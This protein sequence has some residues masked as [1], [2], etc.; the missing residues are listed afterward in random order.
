MGAAASIGNEISK[1][2]DSISNAIDNTAKSIEKDPVGSIAIITTAIVA[3]AYLPEVIAA[4]DVAQ[5]VPLDKAAENY[6]KA[7]V[8]QQIAS[9]VS[10]NLSNTNVGGVTGPDNI[11]VGGGFNPATGAGSAATAAASAPLASKPVATAAGNTTSAIIKGQD[12]LTAITTGGIQAGVSSITDS[13]PFYS[14]LSPAQQAAVK[15]V[16][17]T[18]LRGGDPS[19]ALVNSAINAG[20]AEARAQYNAP[21]PPANIAMQENI[22]TPTPVA[23]NTNAPLG[24]M[25]SI[26]SIAPAV[27]SAPAPMSTTAEAPLSATTPSLADAQ[28]AAKDIMSSYTNAQAP[29]TADT[30]TQ[31]ASS[32]G[33]LPATAGGLAQQEIE[34]IMGGDT[35][36]I[37]TGAY[38][39]LTAQ[40]NAYI[41]QGGDPS[42]LAGF[43][44]F[45]ATQSQDV[46]TGTTDGILPS[47][48]GNTGASA[49]TAPDA[50]LIA[51]LSQQN[52]APVTPV[53]PEPAA[54]VEP[55]PV[56][57]VVAEQ[58]SVVEQ[59]PASPLATVPEAPVVAEP[60]APLSTV[61]APVAET[62]VLEPK[63]SEPSP[64]ST[65]TT[66]SGNLINETGQITNVARNPETNELYT[67]LATSDSGDKYVPVLS[68]QGQA[69][70][71]APTA[72][73]S[74][75][76]VSN[77]IADTSNAVTP[78]L[79]SIENPVTEAPT[80]TTEAPVTTVDTSAP[81]TDMG[82]VNVTGTRLP[83]GGATSAD[84]PAVTSAAAKTPLDQ[85]L[86]SSPQ[87]LNA[88]TVA[89]MKRRE[90]QKLRQLFDSLT[91]ELSAILAER[92]I[93][94]EQEASVQE[95][96]PT[97]TYTPK[98]MSTGGAMT[99]EEMMTGAAPLAAKT[100]T[101]YDL[102]PEKYATHLAAAPVVGQAMTLSPLKHLAGGL[103]MKP[104]NNLTVGLA[105]GGLPTKYAEAAPKGHNPEF[106]TGVTGY[107]AGGKGTGQSDDIPAMLHD[108]DYVMDADAVAA[109]GDGSSKAGGEA[110]MK[111]L[112]QIPHEDKKSGQPVPAKIADGEVVLPAS[113]VTALGKGDNKY[114]AKILDGLREKLR[115]HKR[116]AP[117]SKIPPKAKSPL[118]YAK[119]VKG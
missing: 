65:P 118:D 37:S 11:D 51:P 19:Q 89:M 43:E 86:D 69:S 24:M 77:S 50:T 9:S 62:P 93:K 117:T 87:Y 58:P 14:D 75:V 29:I 8:T 92:G 101:N 96:P 83:T 39:R 119:M 33:A 104:T 38:T 42:D 15:N 109:L 7:L 79:V 102:K 36:G 12:P 107:Y 66:S 4:R 28:S 94:P 3:P 57:P 70:T 34:K 64:L 1:G 88:G 111:F 108:G 31:V 80:T 30:G 2:V 17:I 32:S 40:A 116:S 103:R 90:L 81:T 25:G 112:H 10:N 49:G 16:V 48:G 99:V 6:A 56:A 20:V 68:T 52:P 84:V 59:A 27:S 85:K 67:P 72:P 46:S 100:K 35:S 22:S 95:T 13:I 114:G 115:A 105:S 53:T 106:I 45:L 18:A 71:E 78:P 74:T 63:V 76:P 91:P 110:L 73:L 44:N 41:A 54:P 5:G 60:I 97:E 61:T 98:F 26:G 21:P 47:V 113:F 82:T 55:A 23:S